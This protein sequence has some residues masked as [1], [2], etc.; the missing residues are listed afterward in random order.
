VDRQKVL[1]AG[2]LFI[3]GTER[4]ES[5]RVDNQLRGRSGRQETRSLA[6][7]L[8]LEDDLMRIFGS[9]RLQKIMRRLGME[10]GVPIR[11]GMVS[12]PIEARARAG[13]SAQR[14]PQAP[15]RYDDVANRR[16]RTEIYGLRLEILKGHQGKEKILELTEMILDY[17]L[18]R[19][20]S[21]DKGADEWD[22]PA[23]ALDLKDYFGLEGASVSF[24]E[25]TREQIREELLA[26]LTRHYEE[27]ET[28]LGAETMRLHE[29]FV[30]L[31]VVDQQWKDHLLAL[32]HLKEGIGLRGYGQRDPLVEYKKESFELFTLMKE[33]IEDQFVQY[34]FRLQPIVRE[35]EGEVA[36]EGPRRAPAA[37]PSRRA[38][39]VNYSYG[40]AASGGQDA[41]VETFQRN[42]P[43]VGRNDPCP[44]GSGKKYKKC[45]GAEGGHGGHQA[46]GGG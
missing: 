25:K 12:A 6:L 3:M 27:K 8:S 34:L 42:A 46:A 31:Q 38:K 21:E 28:I 35:A 33:R 23:F 16:Q 1:E 5:R 10:E 29:K 11:H 30:M 45:H 44:C 24:E 13:R 39:N 7:Y 18:G 14:D 9:D 15:P 36:G 26:V 40:A 17:L 19:H 4:H 43:K 20:L 41:K 37:L 2:G 32:D 22:F